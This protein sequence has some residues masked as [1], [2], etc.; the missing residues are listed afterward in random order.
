V[1]FANA[2]KSLL[3]TN[4]TDELPKSFVVHGVKPMRGFI[5]LRFPQRPFRKDPKQA[6]CIWIGNIA[7]RK[8]GGCRSGE[9]EKN[10]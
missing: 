1:I 4:V 2:E 3:I 10:I 6:G 8:T 5:L 7:Y 9:R